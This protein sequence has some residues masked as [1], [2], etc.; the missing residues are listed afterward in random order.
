MNNTPKTPIQELWQEQPLEGIRMSA[1]EVRKKATKFEK[2][3]YWRN[4]REYG[5][6]CFAIAAFAY[7][8]V[9]V[10]NSLLRVAFAMIVAGVGYVLF[11]LYRR[12]AARALPAAQTGEQC[13]QF[14]RSE[15][16]R[17]RDLIGN[18]WSWYIGPVI[19]GFVMFTIASAM[20]NPR[21]PN[22][23]ILGILDV[24]TAAFF[25]FVAKLNSRAARSLQHQIDELD[26]SNPI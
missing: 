22:L 21:L 6:G 15:L 12:G 26:A 23:V 10:D 17:Q 14:F 13:A 19:P 8:F 7:F 11:Q 25:V 20:A 9:R 18:V 24:L 16:E 5:A 2:R 4:A 1:E 3:V